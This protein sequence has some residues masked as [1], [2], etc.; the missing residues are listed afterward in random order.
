MD[1]CVSCY[2]ASIVAGSVIMVI[3]LQYYHTMPAKHKWLQEHIHTQHVCTDKAWRTGSTSYSR[4]RIIALHQERL[5]PF[6]RFILHCTDPTVVNSSG[7]EHNGFNY[8]CDCETPTI[9]KA[10][11][12]NQSFR[13]HFNLCKR[14]TWINTNH[15]TWF[16]SMRKQPQAPC[17]KYGKSSHNI[18]TFPTHF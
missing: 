2:V 11:V 3:T 7:S 13:M 10:N 9:S 18:P 6:L 4:I 5:R 14:L 16:R 8:R 15:R 17:Y 12:S 1:N